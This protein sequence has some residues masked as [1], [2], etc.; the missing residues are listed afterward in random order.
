[1][2]AMSSPIRFVWS[3]VALMLLAASA[4]AQGGG[5]KPAEAPFP[6]LSPQEQAE[7]KRVLTG[8]EQ[9]SQGTRTLSCDFTR[10]HYDP[11]AAPAANIHARRADG[12][13]KYAAPDKG[14]FR[15]DLLTFFAGIE[16]QT[17]VYKPIAG[18]FGEHWVCNGKQLIEMDRSAKQCKIQD[19]PP[20]MQGRN[21]ISS[22]LPFVFNL[23]SAKVQNRYWVRIVPS[24]QPG[25]IMVQ[26]WPKRQE[27]RA[28]YK[29]VVVA[30]DATSFVPQGLAMY[31]PNYDAKSPVFDQYEFK[32]IKRNSIGAAIAGFMNSFVP[33]KPPRDWKVVRD[34]FIA[35]RGG[36]AAKRR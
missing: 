31:A 18:Q 12:V 16:G 29:L 8:W 36:E 20:E 30:L 15:V 10:W 5:A 9:Q 4:V 1:M 28:Q 34:N 21:I 7:L 22:P 35:G 26:A 13:V 24:N 19:L 3:V 2:N 25:M 14:L 17:P 11:T 6:P 32:N 33:E 27:D 23:D